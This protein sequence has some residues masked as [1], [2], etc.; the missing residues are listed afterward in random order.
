MESQLA[1]VKQQIKDFTANEQNNQNTEE[2]VNNS[3]NNSIVQGADAANSNIV[4]VGFDKSDAILNLI[5]DGH[6]LCTMAQCHLM[7]GYDTLLQTA[8]KMF[9]AF[10]IGML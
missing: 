6:L 3:A 8:S 1:A 9:H 7:V 10:R 2:S 4:G 5:A